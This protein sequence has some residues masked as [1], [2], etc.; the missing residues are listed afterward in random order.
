MVLAF[1]SYQRARL[2]CRPFTEPKSMA[3]GWA[4]YNYLTINGLRS[5]PLKRAKE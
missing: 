3:A 5:M 1:C 4:F 2:K